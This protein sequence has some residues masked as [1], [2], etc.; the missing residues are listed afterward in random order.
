MAVDGACEGGRGRESGRSRC[1]GGVVKVDPYL[2]RRRRTNRHYPRAE[3]YTDSHIVGGA[4]A[5]L[6][7][8]N[9]EL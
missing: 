8:A 7:Q 2:V 3:L 4:K 9:S 1:E 6:A 5:A